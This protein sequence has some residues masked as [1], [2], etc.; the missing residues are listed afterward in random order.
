MVPVNKSKWQSSGWFTT[1]EVGCSNNSRFFIK[2]LAPSYCIK[3]Q[4]NQQSSEQ[5]L[6]NIKSASG[7]IFQCQ[8]SGNEAMTT[9]A[10]V[11]KQRQTAELYELQVQFEKLVR[12]KE[13]VC[14]CR[15]HSCVWCVCVRAC[16]CVCVCAVNIVCEQE[17]DVCVRAH[18]WQFI[19]QQTVW[20]EVDWD[21]LRIEMTNFS[22]LVRAAAPAESRGRRQ[23]MVKCI[24]HV[25]HS[26]MQAFC[27]GAM[28]QQHL[29]TLY[30]G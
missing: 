9:H 30:V 26:K 14:I 17:W 2:L 25:F 19:S 8:C 21:M 5:A 1:W 20:D 13:R 22:L 28:Q 16:V 7:I 29:H 27:S 4:V 10:E 18:G 15:N 6:S 3:A 24:S 12:T 23:G 11:I